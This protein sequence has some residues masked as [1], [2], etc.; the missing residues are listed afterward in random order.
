MALL[1]ENVH[2]RPLPSPTHLTQR[3]ERLRWLGAPTEPDEVDGEEPVLGFSGGGEVGK[4]VSGQKSADEMKPWMT[5]TSSLPAAGDDDNPP[6][7]KWAGRRARQEKGRKTR[8]QE[9]VK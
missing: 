6:V 1:A 7:P 2:E 3:I 5:R 9:L 8:I 4:H